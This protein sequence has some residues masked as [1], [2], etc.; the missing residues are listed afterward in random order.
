MRPRSLK[1]TRNGKYKTVR[2]R[3]LRPRLTKKDRRVIRAAVSKTLSKAETFVASAQIGGPFAIVT[4]DYGVYRT[5]YTWIMNPMMMPVDNGTASMFDYKVRGSEIL[6]KGLVMDLIITRGRAADGATINTFPFQ[7]RLD[8]LRCPLQ[9]TT[10]ST[11]TP[12]FA[13]NNGGTNNPQASIWDAAS[14]PALAFSGDQYMWSGPP[15][16]V[17]RR[18]FTRLATKTIYMPG[19]RTAVTTLGSS[20]GSVNNTLD[21]KRLRMNYRFPRGKKFRYQ[22]IDVGDN[23]EYG[24][25]YTYYFVLSWNTFSDVPGSFDPDFQ[26]F[27]AYGYSRMY[28][29]DM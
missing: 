17:N 27:N 6:L 14:F 28:W 18:H 12:R 16:V 1:R 21:M 7:V 24:K 25:D 13:P 23:N 20:G 19:A 3:N 9:L 2:R 11:S 10:S 26:A 29:K 8:L 15:T 4:G 5:S 22:D